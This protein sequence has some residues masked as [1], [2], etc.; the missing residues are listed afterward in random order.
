[1]NIP[2]LLYIGLILVAIISAVMANI[3]KYAWRSRKWTLI[4]A[5]TGS[6]SV[7]CLILTVWL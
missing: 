7:L 3:A 4:F 1:M 5:L 6:L 2:P